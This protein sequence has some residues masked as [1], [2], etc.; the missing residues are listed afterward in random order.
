ML[1]LVIALLLLMHGVGHAIGFWMPVPTWFTVTWLLPGIGFLVGGW[2]CWQRADW[3][4]TVILG[5]AILSLVLV[6][7]TGALKPGPLAS[8]LTFD[9][10][11]VVALVV[12][13]TRRLVLG[14]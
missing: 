1:H 3:W 9:L 4:P 13:W 11:I 6:F 8:A 14:L 2:A 7:P 5:S 10:A 12:P